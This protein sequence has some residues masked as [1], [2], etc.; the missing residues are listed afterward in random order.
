MFFFAEKE[1]NLAFPC[2]I[3]FFLRYI[4]KKRIKTKDMKRLCVKMLMLLAVVL[5]ASCSVDD[6]DS[7]YIDV[8]NQDK[9]M[10]GIVLGN[11]TGE[12]SLADHEGNL[13]PASEDGLVQDEKVTVKLEPSSQYESMKIT[14]SSA[15]VMLIYR[16]LMSINQ[17]IPTI[18]GSAA[19][20]TGAVTFTA[21]QSG[22]NSNKMVFDLVG[23]FAFSFSAFS[24]EGRMIKGE[25][26][27]LSSAQCLYTNDFG[28][29]DLYLPIITIRMEATADYVGS[30][31]FPLNG[32]YTL[33]LHAERMKE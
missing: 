17:P 31:I 13:L 1:K 20:D 9:S 25:C 32:S 23:S 3:F 14:V 21:D 10:N 12:W 24:E 29:I 26:T 11:Y 2:K 18:P 16:I 4:D 30:S 15:P 5:A 6:A 33:V 19:G 8:N 7:Q 28:T 22:L 27:F